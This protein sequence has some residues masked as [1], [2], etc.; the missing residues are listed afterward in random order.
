MTTAELNVVWNTILEKE[1]ATE[2]ELALVCSINGFTMESMDHVMFY[3]WGMDFE[4]MMEEI[5]E[6]L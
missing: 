4:Q 6:T 2:K 1:W 5:G 3:F